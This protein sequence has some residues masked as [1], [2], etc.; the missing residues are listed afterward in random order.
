MSGSALLLNLQ[1]LN[2]QCSRSLRPSRSQLY[3]RPSRIDSP[4]ERA[5][6]ANIIGSGSVEGVDGCHRLPTPLS[7]LRIAFV[8][9]AHRTIRSR[10]IRRAGLRMSDMRLWG[11]DDGQISRATAMQAFSLSI[12]G[13]NAEYKRTKWHESHLRTRYPAFRCDYATK[14][15]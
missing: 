15:L 1:L 2:L 6:S 11:R 14:L 8:S 12:G 9:V 10:R 13:R 5:S 7:E 3:L 4:I